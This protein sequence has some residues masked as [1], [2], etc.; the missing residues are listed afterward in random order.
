MVMETAA[1][2][3]INPDES[4]NVYAVTANMVV[5][6]FGP[7]RVSKNGKS[8]SP[9]VPIVE[10]RATTPTTGTISGNVMLQNVR[11]GV[12]PSTRA[13]SSNS[14]GT[15]CIAAR[16]LIPKNGTPRH[17][18][19]MMSDAI[20]VLPSVRKGM[21]FERSFHFTTRTSLITLNAG[22]KS[23]HQISV[24][25]TVGKQRLCEAL[26]DKWP[27]QHDCYPKPTNELEHKRN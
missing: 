24:L 12:A 15:A 27:V 26:A 9:S 16:K 20:A 23:H 17:T 21:G 3:P 4:D 1:P 18:L 5:A 2:R 11:H 25:N 10:I 14:S 6:S 13:A 8:K 19:T 7:P 22:S